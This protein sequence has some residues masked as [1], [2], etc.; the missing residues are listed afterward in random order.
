MHD[1]LWLT[2]SGEVKQ[3][4]TQ[5]CMNWAPRAPKTFNPMKFFLTEGFKKKA[6]FRSL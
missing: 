3:I 6:R 5:T 4:R 1:T 2:Q